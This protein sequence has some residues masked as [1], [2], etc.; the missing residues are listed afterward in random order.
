[1]TR[2]ADIAQRRAERDAA[3][4]AASAAEERVARLD[5]ALVHARRTG[6]DI[7]ALQAQRDAAE[8][9]LQSARATGARLGAD[10]LAGLMDYLTQSPDAILGACDDALPFVMLPVRIETKFAR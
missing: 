2:P 9:D 5:A 6:G 3:L 8:R 1:M 10:A 7:A 4:A